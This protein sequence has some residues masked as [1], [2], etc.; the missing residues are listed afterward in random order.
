MSVIPNNIIYGDLEVTNKLSIGELDIKSDTSPTRGQVLSIIDDNGTVGWETIGTGGSTEDTNTTYTFAAGNNVGA[1]E[2]TPSGGTKQTV[3]IKMPTVPSGTAADKNY[4]TEISAASTDLPTSKAVTD[5]LAANYVKTITV[6]GATEKNLPDANGN[7][8]LTIAVES[9]SG[10]TV[11]GITPGEGLVNGDT[12]STSQ[13]EIRSAGTISIK[14]GGVTNDML[15]GSITNAKLANSKIT[16]AGKD[17]S[18][19]SSITAAALGLKTTQTPIND[20]SVTITNNAAT[21][22]VAN[23]SQDANG[24]ITATKANVAFPTATTTTLG[25]VKV[26]DGLSI[27]NGVIKNSGIINL[28]SAN[29]LLSITTTSA[30]TQIG[31]TNNVWQ[32]NSSIDL[33]QKRLNT[34][35]VIAPAG[36]S[37]SITGLCKISFGTDSIAQPPEN[38][39]TITLASTDTVYYHTQNTLAAWTGSSNITIVGTIASGTWEGKTIDISHGGTGADKKADARANLGI[40]IR[41]V[42]PT[43]SDIQEGDIWIEIPAST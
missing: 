7:V 30:G 27:T 38:N 35:A 39:T 24:K 31:L 20:T 28:T 33:E 17:V 1:L 32:I 11:T 12:N 3:N 40:Y 18:L 13:T 34:F 8:D 36:Q 2:I 14:K 22:F 4:T 25:M 16:I 42:T 26:G 37:G 43:D 6:N 10:G 21:T 23:I 5:Y 9:T 41:S 15:A 19:G 29:D